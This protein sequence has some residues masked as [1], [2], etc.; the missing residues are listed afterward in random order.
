MI[1]SLLYLRTSRLDIMQGIGIVAI[2][3]AFPRE[4]HA[5]V[6]KRIFKYLQ[7][8]IEYGL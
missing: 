7:G 3:Q 8:T 5:V 6:V 4:I 2:F 1:G